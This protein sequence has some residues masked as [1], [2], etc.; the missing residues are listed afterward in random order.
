MFPFFKKI[1]CIRSLFLSSLVITTP[2]SCISIK[3]EA[4]KVRPKI[5]DVNSN[6]SIFCPFS[7]KINKC[8][9]SC[10]NINNPYAKICVPDVIKELNVR[11]FNL[12]STRQ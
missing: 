8:N 11:A 1:F 6:N 9:G 4:C 10:Y 3:N 5:V 2:L 12:M 7:I